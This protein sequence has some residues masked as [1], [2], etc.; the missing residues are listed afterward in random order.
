MKKLIFIS[1][2]QIFPPESGGQVRSANICRAYKNLGY[3]VEIYSFTGRKKDYLKLKTTSET[4]IEEKLTERVNRNPIMGLTQFIFYILKLP[5]LWLVWLTQLYIPKDL[6]T[7]IKDQKLIIIDFPYLFPIINRTK[8]KV[9]VNTHNAEYELFNKKPL[10]SKIV[11]TYEMECFQ[12]AAQIYFCSEEDAKKYSSILSELVKKFLIVP[13]GVDVLSFKP[14]KEIRKNT[15]EKLKINENQKVILFTGSK[16]GP[17][18]EAFK[19]LESWAKEN[20]MELQKLDILILVVGSVSLDLINEKHLKVLGKVESI[21]PFL[22]ASDFGI[23]PVIE[24]SGTNIKMIEFMASNLPIISTSFGTRGFKLKDQESCYFFE[25]STLLNTLKKITA[26]NIQE[27]EMIATKAL[28]QNNRI[29]DMR[30]T[31]E[32]II[33]IS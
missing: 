16:Y 10:L 24:G 22:W 26:L 3:K 19:F 17:N 21:F 7:L 2:I 30:T 15:R 4:I 33:K 11:K 23:N 32:S 27:R 9:I 20:V 14:E 25:R 6:K 12:K 8:N 31:F 28:D 13:N 29:I 1:G 5:P 18:I